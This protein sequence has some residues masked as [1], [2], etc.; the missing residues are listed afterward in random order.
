MLTC[1]AM[2]TCQLLR[3]YQASSQRCPSLV[4]H[5]DRTVVRVPSRVGWPPTPT[6]KWLMV[7]V[8]LPQK[9]GWK[10]LQSNNRR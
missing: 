4:H 7:M 1:H 3:L 2:E 9:R 10:A 8:R 5:R 6:P